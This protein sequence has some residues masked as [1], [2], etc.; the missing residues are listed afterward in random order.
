M[1]VIFT[2]SFIGGKL[3]ISFLNPYCKDWQDLKN[4]LTLDILFP[5]FFATNADG[6]GKDFNLNILTSDINK[7]IFSAVKLVDS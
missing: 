2:G 1:F 3:S 5:R 4:P 6:T 7:L